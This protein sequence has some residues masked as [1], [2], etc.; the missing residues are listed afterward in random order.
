[1]NIGTFYQNGNTLSLTL[2]DDFYN[3]YMNSKGLPFSVVV[4]G[5]LASFTLGFMASYWKD[6][7][8]YTIELDYANDVV[9]IPMDCFTKEGFIKVSMYATSSTQIITTNVVEVIVNESNTLVANNDPKDTDDWRTVVTNYMDNMA[10]NGN[11][12]IDGSVSTIKIADAAITTVKLADGS[13]TTVKLGNAS[14][15]N[16]KLA[17]NSVGTSNIIDA[18]I[19]TAKLADGSV[20]A[21]KIASNAVTTVKI[22]DANVTTSKIADSNVTTAKIA[23]GS[24]TANKIATI[25]TQSIA[26]GN[27]AMKA[28]TGSWNVAVGYNSLFSNTAGYSNVALG[29]EALF[30]NTTGYSNVALGKETLYSNTTGYSNT[31][32]GYRTLSEN[33]SGSYN[34]AIGINSLTTNTTGTDN[35]AIGTDAARYITDGTTKNIMTSNSIFL[36]SHTWSKTINDDNTIVI[37]YRAQG[38]GSNTTSIGNG[39][40]TDSY[41][42]GALHVGSIPS[43]ALTGINVG[44]YAFAEG[45]EYIV[46]STSTNVPLTGVSYIVKK[47]G[48]LVVAI[49]TSGSYIGWTFFATYGSITSASSWKSPFI[50]Q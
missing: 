6:N 26:L 16:A 43:V 4:D 18:N 28:N 33:T 19:T 36:G 21:S 20:S 23:D 40:I 15:T 39:S 44:T 7:T 25:G 47:I 46:D 24:I 49:M 30:S 42:A 3:I 37:G 12:L 22:L 1:M 13:V 27:G 11:K 45:I 17:A 2:N 35:I 32:I 9:T 8:E 34:I 14:V 5:K 38:K 31:G 48:T 50:M 10:L 29:K 41:I